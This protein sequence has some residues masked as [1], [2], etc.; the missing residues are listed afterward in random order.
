MTKAEARRL[1][2]QKRKDLSPDT[3][4]QYNLQLYHRFFTSVDLS[5]V[6]VLHTYLPLE[7]NKEPDTWMIIDRVK[8]EFPY[9]K[10]S[11]PRIAG[12]DRLENF[13]FEGPA[14]LHANEWGIPEP[15]EGTLT[16]SEEIDMVIVPLLAFD[17][18]GHRVGYGKGFY[19]RFLK[20][21]RPDCQK[22]GLSFFEPVEKID[23]ITPHDFPLSRCVTPQEAYHF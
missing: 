18:T 1:F 15:L 4:V 16:P 2:L 12:P 19:D 7:K 22:I 17:K 6:R 20:T 11:L 8:R 21:C 3:C 5:F 23:D 13:Y 9:V 10:I 14:Q